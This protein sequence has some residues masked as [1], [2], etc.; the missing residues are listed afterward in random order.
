MEID[1]FDELIVAFRL[2]IEEAMEFDFI[3]HL[4]DVHD[5]FEI[6]FQDSIDEALESDDE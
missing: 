6:A 1:T 2:L 5:A 3:T 4:G